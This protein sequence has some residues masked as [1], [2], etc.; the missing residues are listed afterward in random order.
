MLLALTV[1]GQTQLFFT[2][3]VVCYRPEEGRSCWQ[4]RWKVLIM[5][6]SAG[7]RSYP[8]PPPPC[9]PRLL[10]S[11]YKAITSQEIFP[12]C[13][14]VRWMYCI[15]E[16]RG[17]TFQGA[18]VQCSV[19]ELRLSSNKAGITWIKA[20]QSS[21]HRTMAWVLSSTRHICALPFST[22]VFWLSHPFH[23]LCLP[24]SF[25]PSPP[26]SPFWAHSSYSRRLPRH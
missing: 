26:P 25:P 7:L 4:D 20:A 5:Q 2:L 9:R 15:C 17:W 8:P 19:A 14:W 24:L 13:R 22:L 16:L 1:T 18:K 23:F 3:L 12:Q 21:Y 6:A 11:A 10:L